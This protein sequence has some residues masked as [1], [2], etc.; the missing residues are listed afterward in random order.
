MF[1]LLFCVGVGIAQKRCRIFGTVKNMSG[2]P[3][4]LAN[5]R[6]VSQ[7]IGTV[8]SLDGNYSFYCNSEDSVVVEAFMIGY[9]TR[10]K[11]FSRPTD[12]CRV[13]FVLPS[14]SDFIGEATVV[15]QRIQTGTTQ[16]LSPVDHR[17]QPSATG[18]A[19]EEM[20][21]TQAGVSTHNELSSQYNVRGGS[22]DENVVYL[23]GMEVYRPMLVRSGQQEG[24][25]IINSDMV[26]RIAFSSG[27]FEARYGD[28]MSSV[29]DIT[30]RRPETLEAKASAS[31][32]GGGVYVGWG[33]KKISTMASVRYKTTRY[34]LGSMDTNGEYNPRFF[35]YQAYLNWRPSSKWSVDLLGNI[36][37]NTFR[38]EPEDRETKFGTMDQAKSFKVYFDGNEKD[39][40]RTYYA[41]TTLTRHFN[42][43]TYLAL[44]YAQF[45]TKEQETYDIQGEYWL[46]EATTQEQLGVGTYMEHARNFLQAEV[47]T[48]GLR[49][50]TRFTGHTLQA[51]AQFQQQKIVEHAREW[52]MRDSMGYSLPTD[53]QNLMLIYSLKSN[54]K[55][56]SQRWEAFAQDSWRFKSKFGLFNVTYGLR[57]T[58]WDW[59]DEAILSPRLSI[60]L[61]PKNENL[62][63]RFATGLYYQ[64]PF[65]KELKDSTLTQGIATVSLNKNIKSQRS[66]HFVLG[67][68]YT[69]RLFNRPFKFT[70]EAYYKALANLIP[71]TVDNVRV[72][73]YGKNLSKGYAAGLDLKLF[74]EFVPGTDSWITFSVMKTEEKLNGQW[75]PR[76]T[77]QR[78]NLSLYF[79]DYFPGSTRWRMTLKAAMADGLPF[80]PSHSKREAHTFRAP[81]YKRVDMGLSYALFNNEDPALKY[82]PLWWA[83]SAWIGIDMLNLLDINNVNSYYWITD[84]TRTQYAVPNY[85]TGR[86]INLR[87]NIA[88]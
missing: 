50:R 25:S 10:R 52:E 1:A 85:L 51:G 20:I 17:F 84:I 23:N 22:F 75:L 81:A 42:P 66:T 29:L 82:Q 2:E 72:V 65:Y 45:L 26:E 77:D 44:Q 53:P 43:E 16:I 61:L 34:L 32:L 74:G 36:S 87:L 8:T 73:Y 11:T 49:F 83:K 7:N 27:G 37:D 6:V 14:Y 12:S 4:E 64:T 68:D 69:F 63:L 13:D 5:V 9:H 86:Q 41:A 15:G 67:G 70:T 47:Q 19:V 55:L 80:G 40:F 56:T 79:T 62:T 38:F 39:Y 71:Y 59:N 57:F 30:Y 54:Q 58:H 35:D 76:P 60:G 33:N 18:N 3:I 78:Y 88:L 24:L 28:K 21:A 48:V 31:M 46:N